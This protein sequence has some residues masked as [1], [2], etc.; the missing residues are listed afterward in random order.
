M[1]RLLKIFN[2]YDSKQLGYIKT[3]TIPFLLD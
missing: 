1:Q 3:K 2:F